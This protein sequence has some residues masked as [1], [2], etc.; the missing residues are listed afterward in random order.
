[1]R[2][3]KRIAW[4]ILIIS[5]ICLYT[6]L[7]VYSQTS[8]KNNLACNCVLWLRANRVQNLPHGLDTLDGKKKIINS[9][10]PIVGSV[11]V[12]D[13]FGDIGHVAYVIAVNDDGTLEVEE[14]NFKSCTLTK[15]K[16]RENDKD[17][18]VIGYYNPNLKSSFS[19][20]RLEI[21]AKQKWVDTGLDVTGKRIQIKYES[22]RW[23]N[24]GDR[25]IFSDGAGNGR[26]AGLIV[27]TAPFRSLVGKTDSGTFYVG[28]NYEGSP[29][30]GKLYLSINDTENFSDNIGSL[31]VNISDVSS[32]AKTNSASYR[33]R[34]Y[35]VDDFAAVFINGSP[36]IQI[37]YNQTR[38]IDITRLL[39][40]GNNKI[41]FVV[42]NIQEEFTYGFEIFRNN[43][44]IFHDECGLAGSSGCGRNT[45][46]GIVYERFFNLEY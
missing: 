17:F 42:K 26:W 39:K 20:K 15:R 13:I 30:S 44:T 10:K 21:P 12:M 18:K 1:M 41:Q 40:R 37:G 8:D 31:F 7:T 11:A 27:Q 34:I 46:L 4:L 16:G 22:G 38:E 28:N 33:V 43:E 19:S 6:P 36:L 9:N 5:V 32:F 25:P 3:I 14:A 24:G 35:N 23:S 45:R 2:T 29:G